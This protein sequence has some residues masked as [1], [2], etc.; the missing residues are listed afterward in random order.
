MSRLCPSQQSA[1]PHS[2]DFKWSTS[3]LYVYIYQKPSTRPKFSKRR[4]ELKGQG[5]GAWRG[6]RLQSG[7]SRLI[8]EGSRGLLLSRTWPHPSCQSE[9][10]CCSLSAWS[11]PAEGLSRCLQGRRCLLISREILLQPLLLVPKDP[12]RGWHAESNSRERIQARKG[13]GPGRVPRGGDQEEEEEEERMARKGLLQEM[14]AP[15]RR[16]MQRAMTPKR[17]RR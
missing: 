12:R 10:W 2:P 17:G 11:L 6:D 14:V 1:A 7:R 13:K 15:K 4:A 16:E 5:R 8:Q 3:M 9:A